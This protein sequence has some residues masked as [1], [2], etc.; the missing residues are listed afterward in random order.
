VAK[1]SAPSHYKPPLRTPRARSS[2]PLSLDDQLLY[3]EKWGSKVEPC[4]ECKEAGLGNRCFVA[5]KVS[6]KCGNCIHAGKKCHFFTTEKNDGQN[7]DVPREQG[8]FQEEI[9][10]QPEPAQVCH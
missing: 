5:K 8:T 9:I 7:D 4:K 2:S 6:S 10:V 1:K 3:I